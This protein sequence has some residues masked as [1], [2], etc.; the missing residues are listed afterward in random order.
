MDSHGNLVLT[1]SGNPNRAVPAQVQVVAAKTGTFYGVQMTAGNIY[2]VAGNGRVLKVS[3]DGGPAIKAGLGPNIGQLQIDPD[4]N[5]VI[6]DT[7]GNSIRVV[8]VR[9]G[10][11]Y[12]QA[13]TAGN[14]YTIAGSGKAGFTGDG[15][16]ATHAELNTPLGITQDSSQNLLIADTLNNRVRLVAAQTGTFYGQQVVAGDMYT[17]AGCAPGCREGDGG[18]ALKA[19]I[20]SPDAVA[21]DGFGNIIVCERGSG[22]VSTDRRVRAIASSTG[23]MYGQSMNAGDIYTVAGN[24]SLG[25]SGDGGSALKAVMITS[26]S[27]MAV[28]SNGNLVIAAGENN[29]IRVVAASNGQFY[30]VQMKAGHIYN[31]AGGGCLPYCGDVLTFW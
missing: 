29:R 10:T 17:I 20:T 31:V 19:R 24:G 3:G 4:G 25:F 28:D 7:S 30:G 15:G 12:G 5:L 21:V 18:P 1:D 16:P 14:I 11:F 27:R 2:N 6:A 22:R 8:A 13:M 9:N 26:S 23:H